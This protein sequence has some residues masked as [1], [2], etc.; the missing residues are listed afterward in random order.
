M[1]TGPKMRD[2]S[3]HGL[4]SD[5]MPGFFKISPLSIVTAIHGHFPFHMH[6]HIAH[7]LA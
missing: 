4:G 5:C 1:Q 6:M 3:L 7:T 2:S